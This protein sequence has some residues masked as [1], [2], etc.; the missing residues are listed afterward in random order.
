LSLAKRA[1]VIDPR[2]HILDTLAESY[3]IN[4]RFEEAIQTARAALELSRENRPYFKGQLERF[5][6]AGENKK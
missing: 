4:G 2:A 3:Y 6:E 1:A 5:R